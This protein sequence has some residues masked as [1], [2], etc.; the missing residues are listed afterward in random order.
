[1][2]ELN[3]QSD[4]FE[5]NDFEF[6]AP[7]RPGGR[8]LKSGF[9]IYINKH[10][11]KGIDIGL[12]ISFSKKLLSRMQWSKGDQVVV[13][14]SSDGKQLAIKKVEDNMRGYILG[15]ESGKLLN[16]LRI[17]TNAEPLKKLNN[18]VKFNFQKFSFSVNTNDGLIVVILC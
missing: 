15:S 13:G 9:D 18:H 8:G 17:K 6:F 4:N 5:L 11:K 12:Y 2:D 7:K 16:A 1:M 14:V 3:E 10:R